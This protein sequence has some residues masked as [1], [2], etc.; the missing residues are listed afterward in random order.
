MALLSRT[1]RS[2][3]ANWWWTVARWS[4]AAIVALIVSGVLLSRAASPAPRSA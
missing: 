1:D 4:L 3:L 2:L